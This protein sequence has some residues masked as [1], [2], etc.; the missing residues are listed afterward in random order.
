MKADLYQK[1]TN[2][3]VARA[4]ERRQAL[5][6]AVECEHTAGRISRPLRANGSPI[7]ASTF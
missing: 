7:T 5:V 1:I 6:Q 2:Q 3:I 4:R